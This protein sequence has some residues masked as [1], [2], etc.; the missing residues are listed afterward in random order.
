M[1][2]AHAPGSETRILFRHTRRWQPQQA[3]MKQPARCRISTHPSASHAYKACTDTRPSRNETWMLWI[4][5]PVLFIQVVWPHQALCADQPG[6]RVTPV[7]VAV[8]LELSDLAFRRERRYASLQ[9]ATCHSC[10]GCALARWCERD[11]EPTT[12]PSDRRDR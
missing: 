11:D 2:V 7:G 3:G 12:E 8:G 9:N 1:P 4:A 6:S 10:D 5:R